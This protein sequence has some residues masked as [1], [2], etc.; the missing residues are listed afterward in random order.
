[1]EVFVVGRPADESPA[2]VGGQLAGTARYSSLAFAVL[3]DVASKTI[4]QAG[5][6]EVQQQADLDAAHAE[7][8]A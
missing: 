1:M 4:H 5:G 7:I 3:Y 2:W 6:A 8:G